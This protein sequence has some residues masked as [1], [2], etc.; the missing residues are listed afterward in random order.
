MI[1]FV[2]HGQP[3]SKS[4][5]SQIVRLPGDRVSIGK[6]KDAKDYERFALKQ[7]PPTARQRLE[8]PVRVSMRLFYA[9]ERRDLD[10]SLILDCLQD[11]WKRDKASGERVLI[12]SGVYRNDRQVRERHIWHAIDKA[13]PRAVIRIEP[14]LAQQIGLDLPE[15]PDVF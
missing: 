13:D 3:C 14:M 12:Q 4:N 11:R 1:E 15:P 9:D 8:G 6:S 10:E 2:I 5:T 7:I